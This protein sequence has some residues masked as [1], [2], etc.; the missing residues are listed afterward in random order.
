LFLYQS[1]L[2]G[3][4]LSLS[5]GFAK[6]MKDDATLYEK[7]YRELEIAIQKQNTN[8]TLQLVFN[9]NDAITDYRLQGRLS[10]DDGNIPS[11]DEMRRMAMR[12]PTMKVNVQ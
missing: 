2:D 10:D 9:M 3:Q 1:S 4:G 5:N 8:D 11:I 12:R 6:I 7:Y